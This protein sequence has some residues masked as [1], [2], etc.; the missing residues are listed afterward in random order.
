MTVV[1]VVLAQMDPGYRDH[2]DGNDGTHWWMVGMMILFG[3]VLI[4]AIVWAI[5]ATTRAGRGPAA[6]PAPGV[7]APA[8]GSSARNI[9]DERFARGEIDA[10]E[11]EERK[12]LLG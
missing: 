11:Y 9:L 2:M 3:V 6:T 4:G 10:T 7:A 12:R 8:M 5:V 1:G